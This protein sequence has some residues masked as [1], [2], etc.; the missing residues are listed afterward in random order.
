MRRNGKRG[1]ALL[2]ACALF[3]TSTPEVFAGNTIENEKNMVSFTGLS[4]DGFGTGRLLELNLEDFKG[5]MY[6]ASDLAAGQNRE[7]AGLGMKSSSVYASE[8][9]QY[10]SNYYYNK[11]SAKQKEFWDALDALCLSYLTNKT[12]LD[13][14]KLN[15]DP[16]N[17]AVS[18]SACLTDY[19]Y[20]MDLD[21]T[22]AYEVAQ[23]FRFSNP[24]YYFLEPLMYYAKTSKGAGISFV[25][26]KSFGDGKDRAAATKKFKE[27]ADSMIAQVKSGANDFEKARIAHD[28]V[29]AATSYNYD[30]LDVYGA[31]SVDM[32][33]NAY[34]QSAYSTFCI[35]STVCA[36]YSQAYEIICNGAGLDATVVTSRDHE[37][38]KVRLEH[39]WYN[40]DCT[41][42]DQTSLRYDFFARSDYAYDNLLLN[43]GSHT[44]EN[45]WSSYLPECSLDSGSSIEAVGTLPVITEKTEAVKVNIEPLT[46]HDKESDE[47]YVK[48]YKI[49][50]SCDTPGASIYFTLDGST[51]SSAS[52]RAYLYTGPVTI[53]GANPLQA[54][55]VC[56]QK[57]DSDITKDDTCPE[58]S[59]PIYYELNGGKNNKK[60]PASYKSTDE[61]FSFFEPTRKGYKF[62]GW[63][64][65]KKFNSS[66]IKQIKTGSSIVLHLYAKWE[67]ITYK[68]AFDGNGATS[69][70]MKKMSMEYD[71]SKKLTKNKYK[72]SGYTFVGWNTKKNGKGKMYKD[73]K[74]VKNLTSKSKKTVTLYAQWKKN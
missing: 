26:Y 38:N 19:I 55:A 71:A 46:K 58:P 52:A 12:D 6:E 44:E 54:I 59:Y 65:T 32:E 25:V 68:I 50:L 11:M 34:T 72:K 64:R 60:N 5:N 39:S 66:K 14:Y 22:T 67:P 23:I 45:S 9:D 2:L 8:W 27:K 18:V 41:W 61:T 42:A 1:L 3:F 57:Y 73:A 4:I 35:G 29:C 49:S 74:K 53:T 48:G 15:Y 62:E 13:S 21:V 16:Y 10:S 43:P 70:S 28:L 17:S 31:V 56:N 24:Q 33:Q 47:D 30:V 63:Y 20:S 37:W 36:G 51:P 69:G 40:V 7:Y